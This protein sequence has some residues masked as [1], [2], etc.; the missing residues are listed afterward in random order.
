MEAPPLQAM[1]MHVG[2]PGML[3]FAADFGPWVAN[4]PGPPGP[5]LRPSAPTRMHSECGC[6][7]SASLTY[8]MNA[9]RW[10]Q[11]CRSHPSTRTCA[12]QHHFSRPVLVA[13]KVRWDHPLGT[14]RPPVLPRPLRISAKARKA[15]RLETSP[16]QPFHAS[17]P[18]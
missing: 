9:L 7:F 17:P 16:I 4:R 11:P 5:S 15:R 2:Q 18:L 13:D 8:L 3:G 12:P 14:P 6:I 1:G 10:D